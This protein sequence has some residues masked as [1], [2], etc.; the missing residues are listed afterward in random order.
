MK[1]GLQTT[2]LNAHG[3][4]LG[5]QGLGEH[6]EI[7]ELFVFIQLGADSIPGV[8]FKQAGDVRG[9]NRRWYKTKESRASKFPVQV[10]VENK[11]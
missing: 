1:E 6:Q 2:C 10:N 5:E 8:V 7:L 9:R 11:P 3:L 4:H